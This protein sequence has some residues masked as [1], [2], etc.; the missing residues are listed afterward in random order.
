MRKFIWLGVVVLALI[1]LWSLGWLLLAGE[2][3]KQVELLAA[4]DGESAPKLSCGALSVTGYPF[5]FDVACTEALLVMG[6]VSVRA[7]GVKASVLAYS[8]THVIYSL[9]SPL[10]FEDAFTGS[11]SRVDFAGFEG[12]ARLTARDFNAVLNGE[13]WRI[14]RIS[15][16][17]DKPSWTDTLAGDLL[18]ASADHA[19]LHL[20]DMPEQHDAEAG[21]AGLALYATVAALAAPGL[22][23][24]EAEGS[25]ELE[26]SGLPDDLNGFADP[27]LAQKWQQRGG[28]AKLVRLKGEQPA[29]ETMIDA[30][31]EARLNAAGLLDSTLSYR[32][33]GLFPRFAGLLD[34]I[35]LAMLQGKEEPDG[36]FSN[37]IA[38]QNGEMRLLTFTLFSI[39]PLF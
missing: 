25:L 30:S 32:S 39:P 21:T 24:A 26:V 33:K 20:L 9:A 37:S 19:E 5:R 4:N 13:G 22:A 16:V 10:R 17:A 14:A 27:Q 29:P 36:S 3:R 6:D 28:V 2:A 35:Y 23:V 7:A 31:G 15:M 12:S 38:T 18:Q 34:P 1:G 11:R 8:P